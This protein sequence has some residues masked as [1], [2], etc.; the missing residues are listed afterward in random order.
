MTSA[1]S[2]KL[3]LENGNPYLQVLWIGIGT[4]LGIRLI[5][6]RSLQWNLNQKQRKAILF[7]ALLGALIGSSLPSFF[8]G[9]VIELRAFKYLITPKTMLGGLMGSFLSVAMTKTLL[10]IK[11]E[12]SDSFAVETAL[13]LAILPTQLIE[14]ALMFWLWIVF[15]FLEKKEIMKNRLLFLFFASYG[16]L[17]FFLEYL[18]API[19]ITV[20]GLGFYQFLS[21]ILFGLGVYQLISRGRLAMHQLRVS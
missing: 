5:S 12:T 1:D 17:R 10:G 18:R 7:S 13:M 20:L 11:E 6:H 2:Y 21:V 4:A 15:S 19:S 14:A 8:A 16:V 3:I 9:D